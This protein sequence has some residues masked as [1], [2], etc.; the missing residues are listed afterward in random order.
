M[1]VN[2]FNAALERLGLTQVRF[3]ALIGK[4]DRAVR[5]WAGG[6]WPVPVETAL[7]LKLMLEL[8]PAQL[9][10]LLQTK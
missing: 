4:S 1:N 9:K 3:A 6:R 2:Q 10:K 5:N 8:K 7:L